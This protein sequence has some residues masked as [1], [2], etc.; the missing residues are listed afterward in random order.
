MALCVRKRGTD[1][2]IF[3]KRERNG[4][5]EKVRSRGGG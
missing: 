5:K 1:K 3:K 2:K 4:Y